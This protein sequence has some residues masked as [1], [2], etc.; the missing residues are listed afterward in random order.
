MYRDPFRAWI[1]WNLPPLVF[2]ATYFVTIVLGNLI[3][4]S[5]WGAAFL[6]ATGSPESSRDFATNFT[7]GFWILLLLPFA[8]TPPVVVTMRRLVSP[9][10]LKVDASSLQ[11][12][13]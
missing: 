5:P 1:S 9:W 13:A 7:A 11:P 3:F 2:L 12:V 8:I 10:I 4:A 6:R